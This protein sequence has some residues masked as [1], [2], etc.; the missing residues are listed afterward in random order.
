MMTRSSRLNI[1]F[2]ANGT[3]PRQTTSK[4][5]ARGD[6]ELIRRRSKFVGLPPVLDATDDVPPLS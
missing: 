6:V 5:A 4:N 3:L 2:A 1:G